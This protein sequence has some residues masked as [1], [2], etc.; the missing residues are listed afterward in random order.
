[1]STRVFYLALTLFSSLSQGV[2]TES[3]TRTRAIAHGRYKKDTIPS[4]VAVVA[5]LPAPG[6]DVRNQSSVQTRT[7]TFM[8]GQQWMPSIPWTEPGQV[9]FVST[10]TEGVKF[11]NVRLDNA[12]PALNG[13]TA[14]IQAYS[15]SSGWS[16][17]MPATV[18]LNCKSLKTLLFIYRHLIRLRSLY[19]QIANPHL[20]GQ[21]LPRLQ[22][23]HRT[24]WQ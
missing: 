7:R 20:L 24:T 2:L 4:G 18:N 23:S 6:C 13:S 12:P 9:I 8:V 16:M 19:D 15:N 14:K 21:R 10:D 11:E 3:S 1:M 22:G 5:P 17:T